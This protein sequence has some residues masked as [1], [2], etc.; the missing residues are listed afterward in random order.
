MF[1]HD[2]EKDQGMLFWYPTPG[3]YSFWMKNCHVPLDIVWFDASWRVV[4]VESEAEPCPTSGP[5]PS[6]APPVEARYVIEFAS[7][8]A[9]QNG[10]VRGESVVVLTE[11]PIP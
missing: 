5:C 6:I 4:H 10:L 3:R 9:A 8:V 7:G 2:I 1:R 11:K